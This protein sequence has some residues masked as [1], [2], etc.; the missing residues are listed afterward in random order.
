MGKRIYNVNESFFDTWSPAMAYCLG[1]MLTDGCVSNNNIML[2]VQERDVEILEYFKKSMES[3]HPI[4][5]KPHGK[6]GYGANTGQNSALMTIGSMK[7][8]ESLKTLGVVPNKTFITK[9]NQ[10]VP[11]EFMP[12]YFR[13]IVDGDGSIWANG[14]RAISIEIFS[15]SQSFIEEMRN[16]IGYGSVRKKKNTVFGWRVYC[17]KAIRFRDYIYYDGCFAL[18]RKRAK[19]FSITESH[20]RWTTQDISYIK[21]NLNKMTIKTIAS[22]INKNYRTVISKI[23]SLGL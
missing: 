20:P 11:D 2:S 14:N 9:F 23:N 21:D 10:E 7:L 12:D 1:F 15:A 4:R 17:Q 3:E 13:G 8:C 22:N 16:F 5:I 18:A 6:T 19:A